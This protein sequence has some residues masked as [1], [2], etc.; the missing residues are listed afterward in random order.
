LSRAPVPLSFLRAY[1]LHTFGK[2]NNSSADGK[3]DNSSVKKKSSS[4]E[5]LLE[6]ASKATQLVGSLCSFVRDPAAAAASF[7]VPLSY[8]SQAVDAAT[9]D[10]NE[11]MQLANSILQTIGAV[12]IAITGA[13]LSAAHISSRTDPSTEYDW[14]GFT[15]Q[16]QRNEDN[17]DAAGN[18]NGSL[19][20]ARRTCGQ[21]VYL[22]ALATIHSAAAAREE[23][24]AT[25][26]ASVSAQAV[27]NLKSLSPYGIYGLLEH[28]LTQSSTTITTTTTTAT[29]SSHD[30]DQLR[31][32]CLVC[33]YNAV[34][35]CSTTS[36]KGALQYFTIREPSGI[37]LYFLRLK[38][39]RVIAK[40]LAD[41]NPVES[42]SILTRAAATATAT[43]TGGV[44]LRLSS[45][46]GQ[47]YDATVL[48]L[49]DIGN[50]LESCP[51]SSVVV[52]AIKA[53]KSGN[54]EGLS[55]HLIHVASE[56]DVDMLFTAAASSSAIGGGVHGNTTILGEQKDGMEGVDGKMA[57]DMLF[58]VS[59]EGDAFNGGWA[60]ARKGGDGNGNGDDEDEEGGG[61]GV[62]SLLEEMEGEDVG[63][64]HE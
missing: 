28:Q 25:I 7:D 29:T 40:L 23:E 56:R 33:L 64:V 63:E 14:I 50:W 21:L 6:Q 12:Q 51:P 30:N 4:V 8:L 61:E 35:Q 58:Y 2:P 34:H 19:Y 55:A 54:W 45:A 43:A 46:R 62:L 60:A 24:N 26:T 11:W 3:K 59:T 27:L 52:A 57:D 10:E 18:N 16:L 49:M 15:S 22:H 32:R 42:A 44:S 20:V 37:A 31:V 17:T 48:S 38:A 5:E 1:A 41:S 53:W 36:S 39:A 13:T 9:D 47:E